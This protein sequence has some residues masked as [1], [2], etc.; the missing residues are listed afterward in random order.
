MMEFL[1]L[2]TTAAG[3]FPLWCLACSNSSRTQTSVS[4][5]SAAPTGPV[6]LLAVMSW[7]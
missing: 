6:K 1:I 5:E 3:A 2:M 7:P 4:R